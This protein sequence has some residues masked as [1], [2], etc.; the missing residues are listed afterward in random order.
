MEEH[1]E[2]NK[3]VSAVYCLISLVHYFQIL[4]GK[5]IRGMKKSRLVL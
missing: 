2:I 3:S 1:K 5:K 4:G